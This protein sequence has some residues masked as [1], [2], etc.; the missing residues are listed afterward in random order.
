MKTEEKYD[1]LHFVECYFHKEF[2]PDD[3]KGETEYWVEYFPQNY[4]KKELNAKKSVFMCSKCYFKLIERF[5]FIENDKDRNE[6]LEYLNNFEILTS[7][8]I[9]HEKI[10]PKEKTELERFSESLGIDSIVEKMFGKKDVF[11]SFS[12]KKKSKKRKS[13][14]RR[15]SL[16]KRL[17]KRSTK[18]RSFKKIRIKMI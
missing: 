9:I 6:M 12:S 16:S 17:K 4:N 11:N 15:K 7:L 2:N 3:M 13:S 14:K 8:K 1:G 5:N 18:K 10:N